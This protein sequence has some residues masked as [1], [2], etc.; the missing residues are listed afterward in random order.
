[1]ASDNSLLQ[2]QVGMFAARM[3]AVRPG[4]NASRRAS[5]ARGIAGIS[6]SSN[7]AN[8]GRHG[9]ALVEILAS[10]PCV[11]R[12]QTRPLHSPISSRVES[13][14]QNQAR[15]YSEQRGQAQASTLPS[16]AS[17]LLK[18]VRE[19]LA[20]LIGQIRGSAKAAKAGELPDGSDFPDIRKLLSLATPQ[21]RTLLIA[22]SL[23]LL[24]S[25]VSLTVP[26]A[27]GRLI[28]FFGSANQD[29]FWG[30]SF[31]KVAAALVL[32][33]AIGAGARAASNIMLELAG[34]R[35]IQGMRKH[36]FSSA[37]KQDVEW[38]DK[39]A[40]DVVS[41]LSVDTTIVGESLTS[42]IGDGLRAAVTVFAAGGAMFWISTDLTLVMMGIVPPAAIT[43]VFYGRYIRRLTHKT[44]E[45]VGKMT[46]VANERLAPAAFRTIT[47]YS[48]QDREVRRLEREIQAIA[49][50]QGK[51]ARATGFYYSG[52]GFV[53]NCAILTLLAYGGTL[54][55]RGLLSVGDLTSLLMYTGTLHTNRELRRNT[56]PRSTA[57]LGGGLANLTSFFASVMKAMGAGARVFSLIERQ[58]KIKLGSGQAVPQSLTPPRIEFKNVSFAYPS[59]PD[60]KVLNGFN[61][62]VE[63]GSSIALVGAS[64]VGKSSVH[65]LALRLYDPESGA[66]EIDGQDVKD[67]KPEALRDIFGVVGQ[68]PVM[69][70][71]TIAENIAYANAGASREQILAAAEAA[72]CMEFIRS[73]PLGLETNARQLSGGQRQR[74]SL[75]P[76]HHCNAR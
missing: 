12:S 61:L 11:C 19:W 37:L 17:Q 62:T 75:L 50:L 48:T 21:R 69:F 73:L 65:A 8:Q 46:D 1:M 41:R 15:F 44:Q 22:L 52:T 43:A 6:L 38:A 4:L 29:A 27:I 54:V 31:G 76:I 59:R 28:D 56:N 25:A 66:V 35:I 49:D 60:N 23:L 64:G 51:E 34:I 30:I 68:E 5:Q 58:P 74:E 16:S 33:F 55:S 57:Y 70:D 20:R 9:R 53:G 39:H 36:S 47:A 3:C 40:G 26:A 67:F 10:Q 18:T 32:I 13:R 71:G 42:D 24:S 2:L 45:A 7:R 63:P 14:L 72:H